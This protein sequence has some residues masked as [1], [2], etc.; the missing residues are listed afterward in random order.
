MIA[1]L[2]IAGSDSG[3]EA[4]L[5][6][7]LRTLWALGVHGTCAVT[8]VTA[9]SRQEVAAVVPLPGGA[10]ADQIRLACAGFDVRAVKVGM[11]GN[12]EIVGAVRDALLVHAAG[13]PV[14]L[15]PVLVS[16]S[17]QRLLAADA[18]PAL[19]GLLPHVTLVTPNLAEAEVL[20]GWGPVGTV[21]EMA[22]AAGEIARTG[23]CSVLVKGG[24]AAGDA[25]DVLVHGGEVRRFS[26]P[27]VAAG[28][29]HGSGCRL[30][31][32]IAAWLAKGADM[33]RAV[34]EGKRYVTG[35][36]RGHAGPS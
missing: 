16:T 25:V 7:D 31:S 1:A 24:H 20:A 34:E 6:A 3:G 35:W 23:G 27:R 22:R 9:Q 2:T 33:R 21:E 13:I 5:Q 28:R 30:S 12:A 8:C 32:A 19:L 17:G 18:L 4:G 11:V 29:T 14:V 26:S 10:V 36:L 15:D